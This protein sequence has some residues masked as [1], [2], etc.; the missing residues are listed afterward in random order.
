MQVSHPHNNDVETTLQSS[1]L[2]FF[3]STHQQEVTR[4]A[5]E[6]RSDDVHKLVELSVAARHQNVEDGEIWFQIEAALGRG[7]KL[8]LLS[9]EELIRLKWAFDNRTKYGTPTFHEILADLLREDLPKLSKDALMSLF[10]ACRY[11]NFGNI[12]L[13][14]DVLEALRPFFKDFSLEEKTRLILAFA[15]CTK[16]VKYHSKAHKRRQFEFKEKAAALLLELDLW[17][18]PLTH[19]ITASLVYSLAKLHL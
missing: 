14:P 1:F 11:A 10:Y 9:P 16:R 18:L 8:Y 3:E 13:Q 17:D 2:S 5:V 4:E 15:T 12:N 19:D 6:N 7:R